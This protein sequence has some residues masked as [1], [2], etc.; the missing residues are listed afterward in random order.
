MADDEHIEHRK[1]SS[2]GRRL[3]R[4]A[5]VDIPVL[6]DCRRCTYATL[7]PSPGGMTP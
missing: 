1:V 5:V 6:N 7:R 2:R 3:F 4:A